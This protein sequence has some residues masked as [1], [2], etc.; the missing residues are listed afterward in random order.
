MLGQSPTMIRDATDGPSAPITLKRNRDAFEHDDDVDEGVHRMNL[1]RGQELPDLHSLKED[2]LA[3]A[4]VISQERLRKTLFIDCDEEELSAPPTPR[5]TSMSRFPSVD[6]KNRMDTTREAPIVSTRIS[7]MHLV[8]P[9]RLYHL[10]DRLEQGAFCRH[11]FIPANAKVFGLVKCSSAFSVRRCRDIL[12]RMD[13]FGSREGLADVDVRK[14][15]VELAVLVLDWFRARGEPI[16]KQKYHGVL[17]GVLSL[18]NSSGTCLPGASTPIPSESTIKL[19]RSIFILLDSESRQILHYTLEFLRKICTSAKTVVNP[20]THARELSTIF[21]PILVGIDKS[22]QTSGSPTNTPCTTSYRTCPWSEPL[23]EMLL[24]AHGIALNEPATTTTTTTT[25]NT[26]IG[27][28]TRVVHRQ[29][30]NKVSTLLWRL[31][32]VLQDGIA[33]RVAAMRTPSRRNVMGTPTAASRVRMLGS[34]ARSGNGAGGICDVVVGLSGGASRRLLFGS[35]KPA[36][37]SVQEA[38][39]G[40]IQNASPTRFMFSSHS[41][42][43]AYKFGDSHAASAFAF[44]SHSNGLACVTGSNGPVFLSSMNSTASSDRNSFSKRLKID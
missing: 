25:V 4:R 42:S 44:G 7:D 43:T 41:S 35:P 18:N 8:L 31:P 14:E 1:H 38:Q 19:L 10:I 9:T 17:K 24:Y 5:L 26:V 33:E 30:R 13:A 39:S 36:C 40:A 32:V 23:C 2:H 20:T 11:S 21:G 28:H 37:K 6:A 3:A 34:A 16:L 29:K 12:D 22:V 15:A 27:T